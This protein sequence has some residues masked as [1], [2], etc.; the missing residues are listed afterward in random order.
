M[1]GELRTSIYGEA[2]DPFPT[3]ACCLKFNKLWAFALSSQTLNLT[4]TL[5]IALIQ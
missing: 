4:R 3:G 1:E 5:N 2:D